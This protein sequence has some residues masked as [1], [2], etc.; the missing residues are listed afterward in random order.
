M[1]RKKKKKEEISCFC[2]ELL[3]AVLRIRDIWYGSGD[4][5]L[6]LTD[7]TPDPA[8][9]PDPAPAIFVIDLQDENNKLIFI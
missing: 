1:T 9:V 2:F 5:Y 8:P 6:W 3:D 4:S 7:P